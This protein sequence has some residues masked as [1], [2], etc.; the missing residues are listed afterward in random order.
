MKRILIILLVLIGLL[1]GGAYFLFLKA[2]TPADV[3]AKVINAEE[4]VATSGTI[5]ISSIDM[6]HVRRIEDMF[7]DIKDP[8]PLSYPKQAEPKPATSFLD[9]LNKQGVNLYKD[10]DYALATINVGQEKPAYT[11]VLFGRFSQ[12]K[13]KQAIRQTH[14][15]EENAGGYWLITQ[16]AEEKKNTDP[17]AVPTSSV[18]KQQA[19]HIQNDRILLSSPELM[20]I[21]LNRFASKARAGVSLEK[22]REFRKDKV[23]AGA[24]MSPKEAKKGA[25]DLPSALL[26]GAVS[27]QPLTDIYGGAVVSVLPSPGFTVV[28]D[29]HSSDAAWPQ[30]VKTKYDAWLVEIVSDLKEMP[31]LASLFKSLTVQAEGNIL[32]FKTIAT[33]STLDNLEKVPAEFFKMIFSNISFGE[34]KA[35]GEQIVKVEDLKK[36]VSRFDFSSTEAFDKKSAFYESGYVAGPFGVRLKKIGLLDAE[37]SI[38]ELNIRTEGKGFENL[39]G[40]LM[41]NSDEL[42][43]ASLL[44]SRVEDKEGNNLLREELCGKTRN[45][46]A[47]ALNASRDKEYVDSKWISKS[48]KISGE[49]SVRLK[50]NVTLSQ[51]ANIKGKVVI[52]A[53]T[54]TSVKTLQM[55]FAKKTI[56]NSK[57]RMYFKKSNSSTVKYDL[58]G[59]M[60]R[61]MAVRAKNAKGQYLAD[62]SSSASGNEIK[63]VSKRFKGK[64]ASIEVVIA[65]DLVSKEYP[66]ELNQMD[67]QYGQQSTG[68]QAGMMAISKKAFLRKHAK[69][70]YIDVCKDKQQVELGA[71]VVCLNNFG[72]RWG[73]E[74]GGDFDVVAPYDEVLQND[75]SAGVL[76]IDTVLT[77][78]GEEISFNKTEKV[79]F[80]YKFDTHY[81]EKKKDW[82]IINKRLYASSVKVFSDKEELKNK[83]VSVVK[84]SLTIR[85]PKQLKYVDLSA[86]ELGVI[87]KTDNGIIA[88]VT[89]FEDWSTYIDLQGPVDKVMR[90]MP[91]AKDKA[92]LKTGNDRINEKQYSTWGLSQEDKEKIEALPKKWQGMITI[93]GKPEVIR[94]Y[95]ADDFEIIKHKFQ[96]PIK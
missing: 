34:D 6:S 5:A 67:L 43:A 46:V 2:I 84:G 7:K 29:A 31:T 93:Y 26:L 78:S 41:H 1:A 71:F 69:V 79:G 96:L 87:K 37:N 20:P 55:P 68:Y 39:S 4:A 50:K 49:K 35:E 36:Y 45:L 65:E 89:A 92:I 47:S 86:N 73:R 63:T 70:K 14:L 66:F 30:E 54:Q 81:N 17:C 58:S 10:T 60:N 90:F 40:E 82:D 23:V 75:L 62:S 51:V 83:K 16:I 88:N 15:V 95:Y 28:V 18:K 77:E 27:N 48:L 59:E 74:V 38:I 24:F 56:E 22:W 61:I 9:K 32:H 25:V 42:P 76:S 21:L 85:I 8:S 19:L 53:A 64:V 72:D 52:R 33:R 3:P 91:L 11:F 44:V 12:G 13:L 80:E 94:I 57:V